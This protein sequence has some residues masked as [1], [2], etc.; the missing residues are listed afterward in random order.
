MGVAERGAC[1]RVAL[2]KNIFGTGD[3]N[4]GAAGLA[5]DELVARAGCTVVVVAREEFALVDPQLSVEEMQ[6]FY[7]CMSMRRVSGAGREA[8]EH[9]NSMPFCV[10]REQ[11][12]FDSGRNLYPF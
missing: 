9:A 6:L 10:G 8:Y 7:A 4:A 3:E 2:A 5:P 11:L 1:A 12:A